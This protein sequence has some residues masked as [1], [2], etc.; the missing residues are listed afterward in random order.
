M[1]TS[2][3]NQTKYLSKDRLLKAEEVAIFLGISRSFAYRLL[4]SGVIPVV[5]IGTACRVRPQDLAEYIENN[6]Y[7]QED[8]SR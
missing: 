3:I 5:R 8:R 7:R 2:Q 1:E 6:I 4:Q